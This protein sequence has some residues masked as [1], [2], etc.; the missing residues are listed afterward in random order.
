LP[1]IH[2]EVEGRYPCAAFAFP[3]W[4][5]VAAMTDLEFTCPARRIARA[6]ATT[7]RVTRRY[8][9]SHVRDYGD[10]RLLRA[11]HMAELAFVFR[12][13]GHGDY[14][15]TPGE[16]GLASQLQGYW[17]NLAK[18][19]DPN[20]AFFLAWPKYRADTDPLVVLDEVPALA[21]DPSRSACDFWDSVSVH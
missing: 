5:A 9:Y 16:V 12:T 1:T 13:Y 15:A 14:V 17:S 20:D 2:A 4:A 11:Y 8:R 3:R 19:G 6:A 21:F 7:G 18:T 10:L